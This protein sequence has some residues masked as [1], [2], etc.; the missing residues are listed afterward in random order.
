MCVCVCVCVCV[1]LLRLSFLS[2]EVFNAQAK[3][4]GEHAVFFIAI[5]TEAEIREK[6]K[7]VMCTFQCSRQP[8]LAG[9]AILLKVWLKPFFS[10]SRVIPSLFRY[11]ESIDLVKLTLCI[12]YIL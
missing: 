4:S 12:S 11:F 6:C 2:P 9:W 3:V 7:F 1:C 10:L 8:F 5:A